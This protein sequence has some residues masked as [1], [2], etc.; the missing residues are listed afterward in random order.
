M[1]H[2]WVSQQE[3]CCF[4]FFDGHALTRIHLQ[5]PPVLPHHDYSTGRRIGSLL[6]CVS[7]FSCLSVLSPEPERTSC[8]RKRLSINPVRRA[9][10]TS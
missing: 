4:F 8:T 3:I 9:Q 2:S 1:M 10:N 7:V 6:V 5:P